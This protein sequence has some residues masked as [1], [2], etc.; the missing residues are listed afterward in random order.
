MVTSGLDKARFSRQICEQLADEV[1]GPKRDEINPLTIPS[2]E[3]YI[4]DAHS[5]VAGKGA[6][7]VTARGCR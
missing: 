1:A 5:V 6:P 2:T 3:G 7:P 4:K